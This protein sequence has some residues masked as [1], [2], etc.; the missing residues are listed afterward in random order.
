M[1]TV[2][3]PLFVTFTFWL[4]VPFTT[5]FP[6]LRLPGVAVRP[7]LA[8][9]GLGVG[10]GTGVGVGE[11]LFAVCPLPPQPAAINATR[12]ESRKRA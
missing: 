10:L 6:K 9:V 5:R 1:V 2:A 11:A 8:G 12:P 3:D 4:E 7:A